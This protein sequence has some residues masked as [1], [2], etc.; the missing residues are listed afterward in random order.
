V[1]AYSAKLITIHTFTLAARL[2]NYPAK[3]NFP[4]TTPFTV[5]VQLP[6]VVL[7]PSKPTSFEYTIGSEMIS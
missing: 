3:G 2:T 6:T 1:Q 4:K 5:T 7:T